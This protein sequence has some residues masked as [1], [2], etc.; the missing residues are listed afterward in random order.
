MEP[1]A[2]TPHTL[3]LVTDKPAED[4]GPFKFERRQQARWQTSGRIT[5][6]RYGDG[7]DEHMSASRSLGQIGSLELL[8]ASEGGVGAWSPTPLPEGSLLSMFI[9]G[10]GQESGAD[11]FGTV[12]RC[13]AKDG[14]FEIGIQVAERGAERGV[15][16]SRKPGCHATRIESRSGSA[17]ILAFHPRGGIGIRGW[18]NQVIRAAPDLEAAEEPGLSSDSRPRL[19]PI[20]V[21]V[22]TR[23]SGSARPG[24][25]GSRGPHRR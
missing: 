11:R 5:F 23:L 4:V 9:P 19:E 6:V 2:S 15:A 3:R 8:D 7:A 20:R 14:G 18:A 22:A 12:R 24:R 17:A 25:T 1:T 10:D 13:Q 16:A 21:C